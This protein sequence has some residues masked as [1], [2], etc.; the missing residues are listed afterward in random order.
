MRGMCIEKNRTISLLG[1]EKIVFPPKPNIRTD[2]SNY[3]MSFLLKNTIT[4]NSSGA[5]WN[6]LQSI[7]ANIKD[8]FL[9]MKKEKKHNYK[10]FCIN[11]IC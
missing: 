5:V 4:S 3:R 1:A 2:I 8:F 6:N 10:T 7:L 9:K 11:F